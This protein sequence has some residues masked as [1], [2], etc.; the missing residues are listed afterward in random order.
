MSKGLLFADLFPKV[1]IVVDKKTGE[2]ADIQQ[3]IKEDWAQ[4]LVPT[5][6][7]GFFIS[8]DGTL[9]LADTH[10]NFV[11]CS[12]DRFK[13]VFTELWHASDDY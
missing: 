12:C 8:E 10:G 13:V 11:P 7:L 3:I 2:E 1:F 6:V 5:E 4:R 9:Y